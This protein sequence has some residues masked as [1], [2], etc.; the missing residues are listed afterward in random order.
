M[1]FVYETWLDACISDGLLLHDNINYIFLHCDRANGIRGGGVCAFIRKLFK[2]V[3]VKISQKYALCEI[4]CVDIFK[5]SFKQRFVCAYR[6]P[7]ANRQISDY[8]MHCL[9]FLCDI[10][11]IICT[12]F[13]LPNLDWNTDYDLSVL[14]NI[15]VCF[16]KFIIDNSIIQLVSELTCINNLLI[17]R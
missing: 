6:P 7:S 9:N 10:E 17:T 1:I 15:E 14:P 2:F 8:L 13:N 11:F 3:L 4:F 16:A 12:D 5:D